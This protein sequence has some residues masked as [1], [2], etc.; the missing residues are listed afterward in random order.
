M[1]TS[2]SDPGL[3]RKG[4]KLNVQPDP[5]L[6]SITANR[7]VFVEVAER[8]ILEKR[9]IQDK[10]GFQQQVDLAEGAIR[11]CKDVVTKAKSTVIASLASP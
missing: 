2:R 11:R 9:H 1:T 4:E 10:V 5:A 6:T 3:R 8:K 7:D